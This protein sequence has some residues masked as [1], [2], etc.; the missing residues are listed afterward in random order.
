MQVLVTRPLGQQQALMDA[1]RD[2]GYQPLHSPALHIE[3]LPVSDASVTPFVRG[4]YRR[5]GGYW[6]VF[7]LTRLA[8]DPRFMQVARTG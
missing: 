5:D 3:P 6:S 1:L 4:A 8:E 2:A 7:S